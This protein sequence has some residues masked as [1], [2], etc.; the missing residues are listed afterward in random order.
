MKKLRKI[1]HVDMDA[2]FAQ[3][4]QR[5]NPEYKNKPLIVG[6]PLNRGVVST[7]SYEARVYGIH[8]G[9]PISKAK[10]LCPG[11]I[12]IPV[13]MEKYLRESAKI[14]DVFCRFT[15][16]VEMVGCDEGFLDVTGCEKLFGK[17]LE[18]AKKIKGS[19][20]EA[21][22]LTSSA[23]LGPNKFLA[24]LASNMGKPNGLTV[25][26]GTN[27]V[28]GKI[29]LLPVSYIR[30]VGHVTNKELKSMGIETIGDLANTPLELI[31]ARFGEL[32]KIIHKMS[33]GIDNRE[34]VP[35]RGIK[36][37]GREVTYRKDIDDLP[38]LESTL[39]LLSQKIARNMMYEEYRGKII[40]LKLRF[41]DFKT[42]SRRMTLKE[43]TYG[44]FDIHTSAVSLL[45]AID[46][47]RKK[48][49]LI[50]ISVSGLKKIFELES[51][52]GSNRSRDENLTEAINA[53]SNKFGEDKVMLAKIIKKEHH[54][55]VF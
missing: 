34:V 42:I 31:E 35:N 54:L 2:F 48:I 45:K 49:R 51:L 18:I 23:G 24:K 14:R 9:M 26:K 20:Y 47:S 28:L 10:R 38:I 50:G 55:Q 30:G 3:V 29:K 4:E 27:A 1:I 37:I 41:S 52:I 53:I 21:T 32:G 39:L 22:N 46:L 15:P 17:A 13:D 6:G 8:S 12:Y 33:H 19:I 5:D 43:Y 7:A 44:I 36:S 40:T 16:L 25:L 11:G